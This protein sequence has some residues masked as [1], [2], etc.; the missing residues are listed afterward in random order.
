MLADSMLIDP[1]FKDLD[2]YLKY[3]SKM[4]D[5]FAEYNGEKFEQDPSKWNTD[6][7]DRLMVE[8]KS[9]DFSKERLEHTK[10]VVVKVLSKKK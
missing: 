5:L 7:M 6:Y 10:K 1:T 8:L 2:A 4:D 3:A 9:G